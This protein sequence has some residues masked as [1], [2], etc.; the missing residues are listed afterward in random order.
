M[1]NQVRWYG[2]LEVCYFYSVRK[3]KALSFL[4]LSVL[5]PMRNYFK[6]KLS[7]RSALEPLEKAKQRTRCS[8]VFREVNFHLPPPSLI[9]LCF[10]SDL[11]HHPGT[12]PS[13]NFGNLGLVHKRQ[14][15]VHCELKTLEGGDIAQNQNQTFEW[16]KR[17][18]SMH[19]V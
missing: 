12:C 1:G 8:S 17:R 15:W 4:L 13:W 3:N 16:K 6:N 19:R 9:K 11:W 2:P 14:E 18:T 5:Y 7:Y 10:L